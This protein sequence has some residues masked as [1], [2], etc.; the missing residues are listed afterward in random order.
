L[1]KLLDNFMISVDFRREP[2]TL[3]IAAL[4][5]V[6]GLVWKNGGIND[7]ELLR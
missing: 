6:R 5:D 3:A 4:D 1:I 7:T 2:E